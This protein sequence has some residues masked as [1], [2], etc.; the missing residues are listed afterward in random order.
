MGVGA[1]EKAL[2]KKL[3]EARQKAG[4]TQQELCQKASLS[5][6]TL[7][8]IERGAIKSPSVFTVAAISVATGTPME[9]L[10]NLSVAA[11]AGTKRISKTGVK[12][13]YF[14]LNGTL[15]RS[16]EKAFSKIAEQVG[17]PVDSVETV[18]WRYDDDVCSGQMSLDDFNAAMG[19]RL[20]LPGFN[21]PDYY[22]EATEPVEGMTELVNWVAENYEVGLLSG[23]MPG[24]IDGLAKQGKIPLSTFSKVIDSSVVKLL[25]Y[26]A[27]IFEYAQAQAGV[28]AQN[29]LLVD[30]E[31]L[32]IINADR[33]GWQICR[34]TTYDP[35]AGIAKI[36]NHLAF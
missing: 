2:G 1:D 20:G 31:K 3:Q 11:S 14:D 15:V 23:T 4:L 8:K 24:L 17:L 21:W 18:Y 6:S 22:L 16:Y 9:E 10:L 34:F 28:E 26:S 29:I 35:Q 7:A 36:K 32:S 33:L 27:D 5:Y 25:K 19:E 30:D 13:V 12:F